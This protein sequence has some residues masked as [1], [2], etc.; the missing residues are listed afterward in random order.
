MAGDNKVNLNE[1]KRVV[2]LNIW[3]L[4]SNFKLA[5]NLRR[6]LDGSFNRDLA[7]FLDRKLPANTIPVDGVFSF[8]HLDRS[9]GLLNRVS[10]PVYRSQ[11]RL[12]PP[13]DL[14]NPLSTAAV[15]PFFVFF[16]GGSF[17]HSSASSP[18][19]NTFCRRLF[20]L[21]DGTVVV[22]VNYRRSPENRYPCAYDDG[23]VALKW[24][25]SR[26]LLCSGEGRR[27]WDSDT[28]QH[29]ALPDVRQGGENG[30]GE[31]I[32]RE[33]LCDGSG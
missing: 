2:P 9:T 29:P 17:T 33:V 5:Y 12:D 19:Y 15:V 31:V 22:S 18:I 16:H 11:S 20:F 24:V 25:K 8:D 27:S 26:S 14:Q 28:G 13:I 6:R 21:C 1:S 4:I 7:E 30:I 32:G 10:R 23:W 3:V